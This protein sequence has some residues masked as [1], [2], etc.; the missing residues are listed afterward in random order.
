MPMSPA[1]FKDLR[2]QVGTPDEVARAMQCSRSTITRWESGARPIPGPA[3][4]LIRRLA[5]EAQA[6]LEAERKEVE[7]LEKLKGKANA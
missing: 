5:I 7:R 1:E 4:V 3:K 2:T 6:E